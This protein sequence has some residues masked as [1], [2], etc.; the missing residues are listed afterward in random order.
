[1]KLF[2]IPVL[3]SLVACTAAYVWGGLDALFLVALL[4]VLETTLSFD[5]A[6]VNAKVLARMTPD[7]QKRFLTWG[8]LVAVF[9]ARF[10]F[11]VLIVAIAAGLSPFSVFSLALF[12]PDEYAQHLDSAHIAI[13]AFGSAFLLMVSLKYFF[14]D[15][16]TV[17]WIGA[18]ERH[19]SRWGGIEAI[20]IALVLCVLVTSAFFV[21][22]EAATL[23]IAGI[24]GI[25]LFIFIEGI[26][27]AFEMEGSAVVGG[28]ALFVYLNVLDSAFSLDGVVGA[29]AITSSL[30]IIVA[31]LGIGALFVRTFTIAL[32]KAKTLD[33]LPYL[34]HGAHYAILGLALAML[35]NIFV[36]VPEPFTGL[37][38]LVFVVFAYWSSRREMSLLSKVRA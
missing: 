21:H 2:T 37:I 26:A 16:K 36:H 8:I 5:N 27:Q 20:E 9:G 35:A 15:A 38:G 13:A 33:K 14:N 25:V 32:V 19:L 17:H 3:V 29:F 28:A 18:I 31:G 12:T 22:E 34:E 7:W 6:V 4:A 1:M 24:V 10:V 11:P 30:P 23:L